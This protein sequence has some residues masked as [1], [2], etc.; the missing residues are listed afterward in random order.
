MYEKEHAGN[1]KHFVAGVSK[2]KSSGFH[3]N[4]D[5]KSDLRETIEWFKNNYWEFS[6]LFLAFK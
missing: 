2:A 6:S 4:D 3:F 5:P 1:I